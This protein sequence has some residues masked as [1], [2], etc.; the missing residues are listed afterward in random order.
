MNAYQ[1]AVNMGLKYVY[2][3]NI[4]DVRTSTTYCSSCGKP[5]IMRNGYLILENNVENGT[6][7]FCKS[8]LDGHF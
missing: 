5:L 2:T 4:S 1:I 6:C 8:R 3:G 7:K